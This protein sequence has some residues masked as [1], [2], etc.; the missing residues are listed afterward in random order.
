VILEEGYCDNTSR[1]W[2]LRYKVRGTGVILEQGYC[3]D[4]R[5]GVLG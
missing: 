4:S 3:G 1:A 5:T 2:V